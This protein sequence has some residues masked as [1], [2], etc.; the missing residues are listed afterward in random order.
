MLGDLFDKID[1]LG[2]VQKYLGESSGFWCGIGAELKS[3][4]NT[5]VG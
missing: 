5:D 4:V 1:T 3:G 2:S